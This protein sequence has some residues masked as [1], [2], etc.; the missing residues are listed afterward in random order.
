[1]AKHILITGASGL[2]GTRLTEMLL[3]KGY[4]VTHLGRSKKEG[5][6]KSFTWDV[7]KFS[8]EADALNGV[9]AI[10]HLAG[11]G[12][13]D[14]RWTEERK[15]EIL[16]SRVRSSA[17]LFETL[18]KQQHTITTF[19]SASAIGYYGF[20]DNETIFTEDSPA[21]NDFLAQVTKQWEAEVDKINALNVRV[22][23][24]RLGVV[25]SEKGGALVEMARPVKLFAG[26]PLGSGKQQVSWIH[27]DDLC[28]MFINALTDEQINGVY[29]AVA[30]HPVTNKELTGTIAKVLNKPMVL[31]SIPP[32]VIKMIVGPMAE[33]VL[34]GSRISSAKI[35]KAGFKFQFNKIEEALN[36]LLSKS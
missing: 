29:N 5:R 23:K 18:S 11:A 36:D 17:L 26:A 19:I 13:A 21:G 34:N 16:D 32:F 7:E 15:K 20:E 35:Q 4:S 2:V 30:P 31:P 25:L 14:K 3:K 27:M 12:V 22:V 1:M 28:A 33:I 10:I 9:N 8:M 24:L 6:I